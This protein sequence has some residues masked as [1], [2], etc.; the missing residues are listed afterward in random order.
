MIP[1]ISYTALLVTGV[2]TL[3]MGVYASPSPGIKCFAEQ[4]SGVVQPVPLATCGDDTVFHVRK[5]EHFE[6]ALDAENVKV[7][8]LNTDQLLS[9]EKLRK[10]RRLHLDVHALDEAVLT[11]VATLGTLETLEIWG[12][13]WGTSPIL[14]A[15]SKS[16]SLK[17]L[18][19]RLCTGWND[20]VLA[21]LCTITNLQ[22]VDLS[23][24]DSVSAKAL[25]ELENLP[26]LQKLVLWGSDTLAD[27]NCAFIAKLHSLRQLTI[28]TTKPLGSVLVSSVSKLPL[29]KMEIRDMGAA[30][31]SDWERLSKH[32]TLEDVNVGVSCRESDKAI[33]AL[34]SM[35]KL[36]RLH[37]WSSMEVNGDFLRSLESNDTL[38]ELILFG[39]FDSV[40]ES[41]WGAVSKASV[42][43]LVVW[44]P[45]VAKNII[46][47]L[48]G[49]ANLS[50]L[51]LDDGSELSRDEISAIFALPA[52]T[53]LTVRRVSK[54]AIS[55]DELSSMREALKRR[56]G[57]ALKSLSVTR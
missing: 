54:S 50:I 36:R 52:I 22:E 14:R 47:S 8:G 48:S 35:R 33:A 37:L 29:I 40:P 53:H 27:H 42:R 20:A 9:L 43:K 13:K 1:R 11:K 5:V 21:G 49:W 39:W 32:K 24:I 34:L 18:W 26:R 23:G 44:A 46:P 38:Q 7:S 30:S 51:E 10:V 45:F 31:L 15:L 6:Q 55:D 16:R 57:D 3:L 28:W 19:I 56:R 41:K 4:Q 25:A 2:W 12:V 17:V